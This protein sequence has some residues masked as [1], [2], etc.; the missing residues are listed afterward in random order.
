MI[1]KTRI[2]RTLEVA[3][4]SLAEVKKI[5]SSSAVGAT[6]M[7]EATSHACREM[8]AVD[9]TMMAK[10][11]WFQICQ[12]EYTRRLQAQAAPAGASLSHLA[13]EGC[14]EADHL[15]SQLQQKE[16]DEHHLQAHTPAGPHHARRDGRRRD[17]MVGCDGGAHM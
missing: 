1:R 4:V 2:K 15:G 9:A 6:M 10:S 12:R 11:S 5:A 16:E 13:P 17:A 8:P 14:P 7:D 3:E